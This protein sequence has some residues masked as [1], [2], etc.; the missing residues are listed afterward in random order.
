MNFDQALEYL[1]RLGHET[2]AMKFGLENTEQLLRAL[3]D[4]QKSFLKVQIAGTNGKGSTAVMLEA[5][6]RSA[7]ISTGLYTSPHLQSITE[8]IKVDGQDISEETF[9]RLTTQV[10]EAA[11]RLVEKGTLV[12]LPTFFEHVT[13]IALLAFG[14]RHVRLAILETG[15]GGRLDSTTATRAELVAIT[16]IALDHQEYLGETLPEIAAEKAAII[17]P[18]VVAL[19]ATQPDSVMEVI[20]NKCATCHVEPRLIEHD[21]R[22]IDRDQQGRMHFTFK[23]NE[24]VYENV[25]VNLP[26]RHQTTNAALAIGIAEALTTLGF[27]IPQHAV[28]TGLETAT[29][30]G[31][32]EWSMGK[33]SFLFDGA[34]NQAGAT[35][36]REY[37]DEF[38]DAPVTLVFGAMRD[39]DL[40]QMAATLFPV[41]SHIILTEIKN[42]RSA[43]REDLAEL[44]RHEN[45]SC[46]ATVY[47]DSNDALNGAVEHAYPNGLICVTGSLYLVGEVQARLRHEEHAINTN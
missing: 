8:R 45:D 42:P 10:S 40:E 13:V 20:L 33:P 37:L 21:I 29:H 44:V 31:R 35:A 18:G 47:G 36:L 7:G 43:T 30:P 27:E 26:G 16:P 3:G 2:L 5:M 24:S 32:L 46:R 23:T 38:V 41:A 19:V 22:I 39:K 12:S 17:R 9:A 28:I 1:L 25:R 4:P 34:H 14:E 15:L 6:A 11:T